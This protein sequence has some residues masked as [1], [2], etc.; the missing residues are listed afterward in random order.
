MYDS[1][2]IS[3]YSVENML[4]TVGNELGYHKRY[5]LLGEYYIYY[6]LTIEGSGSLYV[7]SVYPSFLESDVQAALDLI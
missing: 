7:I 4:K 2:L 1:S 5:T 6:M 3:L